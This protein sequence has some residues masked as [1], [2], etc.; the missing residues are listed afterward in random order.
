MRTGL[1]AEEVSRFAAQVIG[2][3]NVPL[4]ALASLPLIGRELAGRP[5]VASTVTVA[6]GWAAMA[7]RSVLLGAPLRSGRYRVS[8]TE[9]LGLPD[10]RGTADERAAVMAQ[11]RP[12][13]PDRR[14]Q[15]PELHDPATLAGDGARAALTRLAAYATLAPSPHNTQPWLFRVASGSLP[16]SPD[17]VPRPR[18]RRSPAAGAWRSAWAAAR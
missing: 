9:A 8:L 15:R 11:L 2:V 18:R 17:A 5:Q 10:D 16:I 1:S 4:R 14:A 13:A 6:A 7:A 3:G 12:A